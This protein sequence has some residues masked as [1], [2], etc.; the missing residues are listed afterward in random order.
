[1]KEK[2]PRLVRIVDDMRKDIAAFRFKEERDGNKFLFM[3]KLK[4][5]RR[6]EIELNY[7]S[8]SYENEDKF[9]V[10]LTLWKGSGGETEDWHFCFNNLGYA[11]R[12]RKGAFDEI[13]TKAGVMIA[14]GK[15]P[16][17]PED[18]ISDQPLYCICGRRHP[19]NRWYPKG[20]YREKRNNMSYCCKA[21]VDVND[22]MCAPTE[23]FV[24]MMEDMQRRSALAK[25]RCTF[26]EI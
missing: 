25:Q 26:K 10:E 20:W 9:S 11:D 19:E 4:N 23:S 6:V 21:C 2:N 15:F 14:T 16:P 12:Y 13:V 17:P 18:P 7:K 1:M 5:G 8:T 24:Y 22:T 3:R